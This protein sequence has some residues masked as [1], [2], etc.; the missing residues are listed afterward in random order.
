MSS[1]IF[2]HPDGSTACCTSHSPYAGD[3]V[4]MSGGKFRYSLLALLSVVWR[5]LACV[6]THLDVLD[7]LFGLSLL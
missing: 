7:K 4:W 5:P 3:G 1:Y 2:V 6:L